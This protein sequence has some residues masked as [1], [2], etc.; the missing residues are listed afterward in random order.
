MIRH[1]LF[2]LLTISQLVVLSQKQ[3]EQ[4]LLSALNRS[5]D[6][7]EKFNL[8]RDLGYL[9]EYTDSSKALAY[10]QRAFAFAEQNNNDEWRSAS[11]LDQGSV[12]FNFSKYEK[13]IALYHRSI[14]Y[15]KKAQHRM[16][17]AKAY[18]NLANAHYER[19]D[20]DS[21]LYFGLK[22][23][24]FYLSEKDT[25]LALMSISNLTSYYDD[26]K[27]HQECLHW[28]NKG[29]ALAER[30]NDPISKARLCVAGAQ[31][32]V[33]AGNKND[34]FSYLEKAAATAL[35]IESDYYR[36]SIYQGIS[37]IYN[38]E[39]EFI[40]GNRYADSALKHLVM[41]EGELYAA[42]IYLTKGRALQGLGNTEQAISFYQK[43]LALANRI[44][45][46]STLLEVY[47]SLAECAKQQGDFPNAL[48][49]FEKYIT[50][51]DSVQ[52]MEQQVLFA[53]VDAAYQK[54]QRLNEIQFLKSSG[55]LLKLQTRQRL[56]WII[57][58][59]LSLLLVIV[60]V[61][62]W[63]N[64]AKR[65]LALTK[66]TIEINES[67]IR[68]LEQQAQM[69]AMDA[70]IK[71]EQ[72]ERSRVAQDLHD[73]VG[74]LLS[75]LKLSL[76]S[77]KGNMVISE[78]MAQAFERS[79]LQLDNAIAEMR[80][81]A[82]NMMPE[83]LVK[84]G[85]VD[86]T[87]NFC[88]SLNNSNQIEVIFEAIH[89][90]VYLE[91]SKEVIAFRIIQELVNNAIKHSG[92][93]RI[94]VQLSAHD[95]LVSLIVEDNGKG[96][97]SDNAPSTGMGLESLKNRIQYLKGTMDVRNELEKGLSILIEFPAI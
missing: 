55:E 40:K 79:I 52:S 94:I 58:L 87:K 67:R 6:H 59:A 92:G 2:V 27:M 25:A 66:Q 44:N 63:R 1:V 42:S 20:Y 9:F 43:S 72:N 21:A 54:E 47:Q 24:E 61:L 85:L 3:E 82:Y 15:A 75:G 96:L 83:A 80:R 78:E 51:K 57:F 7:S 77:M 23:Y 26:A 41:E 5:S 95:N 65:N 36:S 97:P 4:E 49:Y 84:Y 45:D 31:S 89:F 56:Y 50:Y 30:Q 64:N 39:N 17:E 13:A 93:S 28:V 34:I 76:S 69:V 16:R 70:I 14:G 32:A 48:Q 38:D 91:K 62:I 88:D 33:A 46:Y 12:Y 35:S 90:D 74:S 73:G 11:C 22:S 81:V 53:K 18:T 29:M 8:L 68:H 10:Y 60:F 71:G 19:Y 37:G 86:A